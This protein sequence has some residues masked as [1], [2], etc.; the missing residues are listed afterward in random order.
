MSVRYVSGD[1][2]STFEITD[3]NDVGRLVNVLTEDTESG[4]G[5]CEFSQLE[6]LFE[7]KDKTLG[8]H[9]ATDGCNIVFYKKTM[10]NI[11]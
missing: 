3:S 4:S 7:G 1:E 8:I 11:M 6:L 9:P 2:E 5:S 10:T